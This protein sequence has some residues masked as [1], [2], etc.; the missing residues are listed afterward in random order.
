LFLLVGY[1]TKMGLAPLHTWLPDAHSEAPSVVSALLSGA[2][3][4]CAF[5]GILRAQQLSAAAGDAAFGRELL[6]GFGLLSMAVAAVFI[7]AQADYKRLLAYSSVEHMGILALGV[8][9]G[10]A[11]TF[12]ALLH[13][14]NHS[15]AKAMLF[16]LAGNI[17]TAYRSKSTRDVH[18]V[19]RRLPVSGGLWLLGFFAIVG[20]PPFGPFLSELTILKGALDQGHT[21]VAVAYVALLAVVFIGMAKAMLPMA[22]GTSPDPGGGGAE[23]AL[24]ILP[25]AC[26]AGL[27]SLLG[28]YVP[29]TLRG[30]IEATARVVGDAHAI[31]IAATP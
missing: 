28:I 18:G 19:M 13:A 16:L 24:A 2:L 3:L 22:Q 27:V 9:V 8:G 31:T 5:L 17:L 7:T 23:P 11:A 29:P 10:G 12:G 30:L 21:V 20:A 4:N 1:G 26:L 14:V 25:P 15:T 6:V